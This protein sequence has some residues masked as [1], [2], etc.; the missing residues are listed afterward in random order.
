M[1]LKIFRLKHNLNEQSHL[2]LF[3]NDTTSAGILFQLHV[4]IQIRLQ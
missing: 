2:Y 3:V 1:E 4:V